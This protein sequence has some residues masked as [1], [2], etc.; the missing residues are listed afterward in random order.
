MKHKIQNFI[1]I[2][3]IFFNASV[4]ASPYLEISCTEPTGNRYDYLKGKV[5][6][7]SDAFTGVYPYFIVEKVNSKVITV[8]WGHSK[9]FGEMPSN[10]SKQASIILRGSNNFSAIRTTRSGRL[11]EIYSFYPKFLLM[12]YTEHYVG[13][14][15][16]SE[17]TSKSMYAK[18]KFNYS[19]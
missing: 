12:Y 8:F 5:V 2:F 14:L 7:D 15:H 16:D 18:C 9:K 11:L 1:F 3:L 19:P 4:I 10:D 17:A 6:P 13:A